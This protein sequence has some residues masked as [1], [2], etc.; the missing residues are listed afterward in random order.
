MAHVL[1]GLHLSTCL[2]YLDD[3]T[4]FSTTIELL[5]RL[6]DVLTTFK[7]IHRPVSQHSSADALTQQPGRQLFTRTGGESGTRT[8]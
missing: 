7:V 1:Q 8:S 4:I 5:T 2:V 6:A 3:I